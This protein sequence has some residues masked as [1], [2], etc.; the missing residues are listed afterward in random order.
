MKTHYTKDL[1]VGSEITEF[2]IVKRAEIK[3]GAN[4]KLY[5]D[6]T[7]GDKSGEMTGKKWDIDG[8]EEEALA[9]YKAGD[10]V[11]VKA[12]VTEWNGFPQFRV[13]K[14]RPLSDSDVID[15]NDFIKAAPE[16]PEKMYEYL[17]E[18]ANSIGDEEFREVAVAILERNRDRLTYYPAAKMNHHA[19]F[20]GLLY[21]VKRMLMLAEHVCEVY[22]SLSRDLLL[23]GV[24][25]HDIEK[26]NEMNADEN[27]VVSEY[28]FEGQMLGHLVMGVR[29][30]DRLADEIGLSE[31]KAVMLEHMMISH[32]YEPDF[33][34]PKKPLFPEAE[35]LH[36]LD[37]MD[38]KLY[39]F[40][41]SLA[42]VAP[43]MFSDWVRTLDG[44]KLYKATTEVKKYDK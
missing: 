19:V 30:I 27:G 3:T 44:R 7:L 36:Y 43:G 8:P 25:I 4:N 21:H 41:D 22:T 9:R 28:T 23:T 42:H 35:A 5:F 29:T 16:S 38:S 40:E 33:G 18:K 1:A 20:G 6:V 15:R 12:L 32:H 37:M 17:L 39:D 14:I 31:E 13:T 2:F 10:I 26:L 24:I 34:S 11:K